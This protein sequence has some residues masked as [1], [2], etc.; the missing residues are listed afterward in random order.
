MTCP[1]GTAALTPSF[2]RS[3]Q[4]MTPPAG[5]DRQTGWRSWSIAWWARGRLSGD[6]PGVPAIHSAP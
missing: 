1:A 6:R 4:A 2:W 3:G 5:D